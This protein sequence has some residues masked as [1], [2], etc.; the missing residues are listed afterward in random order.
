MRAP[1]QEVLSA[2]T[3]IEARVEGLLHDV[4]FHAKVSRADFEKLNAP[5]LTELLV[6]VKQLL[7]ANG[8]T[9][10]NISEVQVVGGGTRVPKV[11]ETLAAFFGRPNVDAHLNGDDCVCMGAAFY[12]AM[13]SNAFKKQPFKFRDVSLFPV[14][15]SHPA[16][17]SEPAGDAKS[18]FAFQNKLFAKKVLSFTT[19]QPVSMRLKY[20]IDA[21][22]HTRRLPAG[23]PRDLVRVDVQAANL[24]A[25]TLANPDAKPKVSIGFRLTSSGTVAVEGVDAEFQAWETP[26]PSK[27][28]KKTT[29]KP[30]ATEEPAN[31]TK[32]SE[33]PEPTTEEPE[34]AAEPV[35]VNK[36][37]AVSFRETWLGVREYHADELARM[38]NHTRALVEEEH[39]RASRAETINDL[40]SF[41]YMT[42]EKMTDD[43]MERHANETERETLLAKLTAA[44]EW[45]DSGDMDKA[46]TKVRARWRVIA[47]G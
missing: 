39:L 45:M 35:L 17:G 25:F 11:R 31:E 8:L 47:L 6:P 1:T 43:E 42:R 27:K 19:D 20:E 21:G 4:S 23:T 12:A 16:V 36:T 18:L 33:T 24:T 22:G 15:V 3:D 32:P 5:L 7:E 29:A 46:N 13:K 38:E 28:P 26:A 30:K 41:V 9:V 10:A 14:S 44:S 34:P 37:V 2:N 40:E